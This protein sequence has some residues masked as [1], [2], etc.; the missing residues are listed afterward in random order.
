MSDLSGNISKI[1]F[2]R[3]V[4]ALKGSVSVNGKMLELL[5]ALDGRTDLA[6]VSRKTNMSLSDMRPLVSKLLDYGLIEEIHDRTEMIDPAFFGFMAGHLS[7]F[8]GPIA[9]VLVEDAVMDI[10]GGAMEV[11]VDRAAELIE[12]VGQQVPEE[13]Q[14]IEFTRSMLKKLKDK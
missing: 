7:K 9:Q 4:A 8:A 14:R 13:N 2:R 10:G 1:I 3:T 11:P 6:E 5:M 12:T